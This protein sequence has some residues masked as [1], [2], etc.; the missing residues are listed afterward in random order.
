DNTVRKR[1]KQII[2]A[3][4][5]GLLGLALFGWIDSE[6]L[7]ELLVDWP[8]YRQVQTG[9]SAEEVE[10][11]LGPGTEIRWRAV[12]HIQISPAWG[13]EVRLV[14]LETDV[15][16]DRVLQWTDSSKSGRVLVGFRDGK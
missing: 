10:A 6:F 13:N 3:A 2:L 4:V 11:I 9:M 1:L 5:V 8:G 14:Q 15:E 16:G 12:T 7:S